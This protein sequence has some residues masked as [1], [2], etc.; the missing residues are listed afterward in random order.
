M[1]GQQGRISVQVLERASTQDPELCAPA[2]PLATA[3]K[4]ALKRNIRQ[5]SSVLCMCSGCVV[6]CL[7]LHGDVALRERVDELSEAWRNRFVHE[8]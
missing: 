1:S 2:R 6:I 3:R 7:Q 8:L 5:R 4:R